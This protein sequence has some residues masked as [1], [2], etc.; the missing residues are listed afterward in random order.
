MKRINMLLLLLAI[1]LGCASSKNVQV[2]GT[3]TKKE[4]N[5]KVIHKDSIGVSIYL[6]DIRDKQEIGIDDIRKIPGYVV[7]HSFNHKLLRYHKDSIP[8]ALWIKKENKSTII[9]Y[10][11]KHKKNLIIY[12][13]YLG[14]NPP[15]II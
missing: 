6:Y 7:E 15:G 4:F 14:H 5:S 2:F 3:H 1:T 13:L 9:L 8:E 11:R 10:P 12:K